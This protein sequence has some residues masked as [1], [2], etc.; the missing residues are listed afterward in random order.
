MLATTVGGFSYEVVTLSDRTKSVKTAPTGYAPTWKEHV[1]TIVS[2]RSK[3][4]DFSRFMRQ[5]AIRLKRDYY[6]GDYSDQCS[7]FASCEG[8]GSVEVSQTVI[9]ASPDIISVIVGTNFYKA[10]MAHP[11][12]QGVR[13][14]IGLVGSIDCLL[15]RTC[16]RFRQI[17]TCAGS[18][19]LTSTIATTFRMRTIPTVF[20]FP[21]IMPPSDRM[22][23]LGHSGLTN[24]V[25]TCRLATRR[26][27]GRT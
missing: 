15:R 17:A 13:T 25:A 26:S 11:N 20:R 22:A 3:D 5:Q 14:F 16:S 1:E 21:G 4:A 18:P 23:S 12:V 10:G 8:A 9:S 6:E 7:S 2:T 27:A 19:N 24:L